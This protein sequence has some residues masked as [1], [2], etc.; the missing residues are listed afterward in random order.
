MAHGIEARCPFLDREVL[1]FANRLSYQ[2]F[3]QVQSGD[4]INKAVLRNVFS[5]DLPGSIVQRNKISLDV[6][7]GIRKLVVEYLT[8]SG[9][10]EIDI[11]REIWKRNF[12]DFDENDPHFFAY[13]IMDKAIARRGTFHK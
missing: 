4:L 13:P 9:G 12:N 10:A 7:S 2:D 6:G 3:Y 11:L 8:S 5:D 1:A